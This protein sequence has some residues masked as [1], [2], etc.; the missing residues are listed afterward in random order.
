[1]NQDDLFKL[2]FQ[3]YKENIGVKNKVD[4][5]EIELEDFYSEIQ[6]PSKQIEN[7]ANKSSLCSKINNDAIDVPF[8]KLHSK[9]YNLV[10]GLIRSNINE[11]LNKLRKYKAF[12]VKSYK[13]KLEILAQNDAF[14][15]TDVKNHLDLCELHKLTVHRRLNQQKENAENRLQELLQE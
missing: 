4:I 9:S 13:N 12:Y 1:M 6:Q 7:N 5:D 10:N 2:T 3:L 8:S 14:L 15:N 11:R